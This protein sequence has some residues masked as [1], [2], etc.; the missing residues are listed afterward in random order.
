M[1]YCCGALHRAERVVLLFPNKFCIDRRVE[2]GFCP[3]C[4]NFIVELHQ[5]NL[6]KRCVMCIRP[7]RSE[8]GRFIKS[9]ETKKLW[10]EPGLKSGLKG[11]AGFVYGKNIEREDGNIYQ[12]SVDFN[13][14]KKLV[15]VIEKGGV[16]YAGEEKAG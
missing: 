12:Y 8:T 4:G 5:Y 6:K 15:K 11:N 1:I 10:Y 16:N 13:G 7:K 14:T 9:L 3:N 2:M